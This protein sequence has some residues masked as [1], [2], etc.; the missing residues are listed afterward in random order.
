MSN[1]FSYL[2]SANE[3]K[4]KGKETPVQDK[5]P[6]GG[7]SLTGGYFV[8]C[9]DAEGTLRRLIEAIGKHGNGGHSYDIVIDPDRKE[10]KETFIWD[11]DGSDRVNEIIAIPEGQ[12]EDNPLVNM[13]LE[14]MDSIRDQAKEGSLTIEEGVD[15]EESLTKEQRLNEIF[16]NIIHD[17]NL[18]LRGFQYKD[19]VKENLRRAVANIRVFCESIQHKLK[20][21]DNTPAE[22]E[23]IPHFRGA[24]DHIKEICDEALPE[25]PTQR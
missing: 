14:T 11:G 15:A 9:N 1:F 23:D 12:G 7:K 19:E 2:N 16:N 4:G 13:C 22:A 3:H 5:A 20:A 8:F 17:S 6:K 21:L 25:K 24:I 10:E 18:V